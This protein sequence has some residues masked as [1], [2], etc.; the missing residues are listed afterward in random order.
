V[1][2][3][4][5]GEVN[6]SF[7]FGEFPQETQL[8]GLFTTPGVVYLASA[9]DGPGAVWPATSPNVVAAGGTTISRDSSTGHFIFET[10]CEDTGGARAFSNRARTSRIARQTRC[11]SR[12]FDLLL[13]PTPIPASG[14]WT[15]NLFKANRVDFSL[16]AAPV[17]RLR[18]PESFNAGKFT[19][20]LREH[21]NLPDTF[22]P[23]G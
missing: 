14:F 7:S 15:P 19:F 3:N 11:D 5:G 21:R 6:M 8:D 23:T 4:G 20:E 12:H 18:L 2:A 1:A 16:S 10:L 22:S 17:F 9:G 13:M